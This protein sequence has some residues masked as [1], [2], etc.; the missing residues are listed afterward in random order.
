MVLKCLY[1]LESLPIHRE[2]LA[3]LKYPNQDRHKLRPMSIY[4]FTYVYVDLSL[5]RLE[6]MHRQANRVRESE[7]R[8]ERESRYLETVGVYCEAS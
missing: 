6:C 3:Y 8:K 5:M 4:I 2:Q 7:T 1:T